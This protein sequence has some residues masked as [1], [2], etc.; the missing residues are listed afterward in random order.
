VSST[1]DNEKAEIE[2]ERIAIESFETQVEN[3]GREIERD[4]VYLDHTSQ[5]AVDEF[6]AKVERYN[7]LTQKA[8]TANAAFNLKV[9]NYNAK[10]RQYGR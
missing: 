4:R 7:A 2:S 1:L 6:N 10:L 9:D 5:F 3:L 8:K